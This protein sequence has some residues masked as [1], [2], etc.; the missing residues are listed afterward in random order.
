MKQI[1]TRKTLAFRKSLLVRKRL[2]R[3]Y[4]GCPVGRQ[5]TRKKSHSSQDTAGSGKNSPVHR[6]N[7]ESD[8]LHSLTSDDSADKAKDS[9]WDNQA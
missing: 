7:I 6:W 4:P 2:Q 8:S 1:P 9:A 3:R 5:Q